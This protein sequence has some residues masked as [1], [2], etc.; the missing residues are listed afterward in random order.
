VPIP[1][2]ET[3]LA[4]ALARVASEPINMVFSLSRRALIEDLEPYSPGTFAEIG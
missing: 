4:E 1:N 3:W 2:V